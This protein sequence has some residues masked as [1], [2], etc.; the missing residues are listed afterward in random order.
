LAVDRYGELTDA[1][2]PPPLTVPPALG[3][4]LSAIV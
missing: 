2:V 3:D 4:A 1:N